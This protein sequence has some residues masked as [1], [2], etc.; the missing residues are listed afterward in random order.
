M[1]GEARCASYAAEPW[2]QALVVGAGTVAFLLLM[3]VLG[4]VASAS[5]FLIAASLYLD[6]R[7]SIRPTTR[8]LIGVG[9][10]IAL[11][12]I[13]SRMLDVALPRGIVGF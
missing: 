6:A 13:F 3:P 1:V 7:R 2:Q 5:L 9:F 8:L 10:P 11:W 4:F 12:W